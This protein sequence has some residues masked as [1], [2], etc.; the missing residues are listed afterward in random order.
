RLNQEAYED[1]IH[2]LLE[3]VL[4]LNSTEWPCENR[5]LPNTKDR[6]VIIFIEMV[7]SLDFW[8]W[9]KIARCF[10]LWDIDTR[11]QHRGLYRFHFY[12]TSV[13]IIGYPYSDYSF[14]KPQW[15]KVI[16]VESDS[17][18]EKLEN[19][20]LSPRNRARFPVPWLEAHAPP[21]ITDYP[22]FPP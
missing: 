17:E 5:S 19:R 7:S 21:F 4:F 12:T 3:D 15:I 16:R 2:S 14:I 6:T 9:K 13:F 10:G 18:L 22:R 20:L 8:A 1:L 11:A